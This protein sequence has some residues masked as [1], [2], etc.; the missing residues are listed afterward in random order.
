MKEFGKERKAGWW[1]LAPGDDGPLEKLGP[2]VLSEG[3]A[4]VGP[5]DRRR[6]AVS[7][8]SCA[9]SGRW[10]ASAAGTA[11]TS[12]IARSSRRTRRSASSTPDERERLARGDRARCSTRRSRSNA[13]APAGCPTKLGDHFTVHGKYGQP[14]PRMRRRPAPRELRVAR[15]HVLPD[16]PDRWQDPGRPAAVP[17]RPIAIPV[18]VADEDDRPHTTTRARRRAR[19]RGAL[20]RAPHGPHAAPRVAAT[21]A[22]SSSGSPSPTSATRSWRP[23]CRSRST[24]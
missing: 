6:R 8:R 16:V 14:C 4:D 5:R 3:F 7:T 21:S 20:P 13:R 19:H 15:G 22:C 12:C 24:S 2:E 23:S 18:R 1:V 10:P 9:T 11:T 17:P